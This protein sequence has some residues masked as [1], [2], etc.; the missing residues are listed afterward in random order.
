MLSTHKESIK[1]AW[2]PWTLRMYFFLPALFSFPCKS[3][4]YVESGFP[5]S[6][7]LLSLFYLFTTCPDIFGEKSTRSWQR[8]EV[9][10]GDTRDDAILNHSTNA[11]HHRVQEVAKVQS[12]AARSGGVPEKEKKERINT[13]KAPMFFSFSRSHHRRSGVR[14]ACTG[15][16]TDMFPSFSSYKCRNEVGN[17]IER[18]SAARKLPAGNRRTVEPLKLVCSSSPCTRPRVAIFTQRYLV[19]R[20]SPKRR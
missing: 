14:R 8:N 15:S 20:P 1:F 5:V 11:N 3:L 7:F 10:G 18:R 19:I 12:T 17:R 16:V 6:F 2:V 13:G 4:F 9:N